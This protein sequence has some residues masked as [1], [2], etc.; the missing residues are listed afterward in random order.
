MLD[1]NLEDKKIPVEITEESLL[2]GITIFTKILM[3]Q[4]QQ[5]T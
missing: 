4:K 5:K 3:L 1:S 2:Q